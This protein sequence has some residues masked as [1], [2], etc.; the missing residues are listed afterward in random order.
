MTIPVSTWDVAQAAL[1]AAIN[2]Q[3]AV[4]ATPDGFTSPD[5]LVCEGQPTEDPVS[6][7]D[8]II[9]GWQPQDGSGVLQTFVPSQLVGS[10][11]PGWLREDYHIPVHVSVYRG[12]DDVPG[13]RTRCK[14]LVEAIDTA[15]RT[16][17]S[18][19]GHVHQAY[20][21]SHTFTGVAWAG[22]GNSVNGRVMTC[23]IV[24]TCLAL[25]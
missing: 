11:G 24:V 3:P 14:A 4:L 1:I 2:L 21:S 23:N 17:P 13:V 10:G 7:K 25:P 8:V 5:I 18:L 6:E 22:S 19:A 20:P 12:G 9:I 15:V 16:D